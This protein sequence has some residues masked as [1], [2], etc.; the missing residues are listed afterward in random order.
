[1]ISY[2]SPMTLI[3]TKQLTELY[4]M[5]D[6]EIEKLRVQLAE[7][8][9]QQSECQW[10]EAVGYEDGH[11]STSCGADWTLIEGTPTDYGMNFCPSCGRWLVV[12][13]GLEVTP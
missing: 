13:H 12:V 7:M 9:Q 2:S 5:R 8:Q 3:A 1:M 11:W 6:A 10:S 4:E